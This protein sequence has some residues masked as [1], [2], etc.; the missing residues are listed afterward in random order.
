MVYTQTAFTA[1]KHT[2]GRRRG[3]RFSISHRYYT[4]THCTPFAL[5]IPLFGRGFVPHILFIHVTEK[6]IC[7]SFDSTSHTPHLRYNVYWSSA[8]I[9]LQATWCSA[10][11]YLINCAAMTRAAFWALSSVYG[12]LALRVPDSCAR[13]LIAHTRSVQIFN[14]LTIARRDS[15]AFTVENRLA[16]A[17]DYHHA[18]RTVNMITATHR[19]TSVTASTQ[20]INN[21]KKGM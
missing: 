14:W 7:A 5:L 8:Q 2:V 17:L 3:S 9:A 16:L 18:P 13:L 12:L 11:Y 15:F 20:K 19:T 10:R 1:F 4:P 6:C 21:E